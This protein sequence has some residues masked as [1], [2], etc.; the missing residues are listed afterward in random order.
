[1][2]FIRFC[3][4]LLLL[5]IFV[6]LFFVRTSK[7]QETVTYISS[8]FHKV[9]TLCKDI[10]N[11]F[12]VIQSD[13]AVDISWLQLSSYIIDQLVALQEAISNLLENKEE[14]SIYLTEDYAYL[15][16]LFSSVERKFKKWQKKCTTKADG[17]VGVCLQKMIDQ[18]KKNLQQI[19]LF[20]KE[21]I[22][23]L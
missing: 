3:L 21:V 5:T 15:L 16:D 8:D 14:V 10:I 11:D 20:N 17:A 22:G 9:E 12:S 6:I 23:Y 2:F 7:A 4:K 13:V 19:L 18:S 1:M